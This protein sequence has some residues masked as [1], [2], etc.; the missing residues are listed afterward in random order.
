[1]KINQLLAGAAIGC[2]LGTAGI[3]L[4][5]GIANAAPQCP[6]GVQCGPGGGGGPGG[7]PPGGPP[8]ERGPGNGPPGERAP[9][10]LLT[11]VDPV[12]HPAV[13][14]VNSVDR[15]GVLAAHRPATSTAPAVMIGD[16][17]SVLRTTTG[18]GGSTVPL[19]QRAAA[20][21]LGRAAAADM[22]RTVAA[23]MG[24]AAAA[25]Q[26]L[27]LQRATGVGP[28]LQPVGFLFLR[29]LDSATGLTDNP[30]RRPPRIIRGGRQR[31][32]AASNGSAG[33]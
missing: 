18:A 25:D 24:P 8:G 3:S 15:E 10:E 28:R 5:S 23:G 31:V 2:M 21:G 22:G 32:S 7:P 13:R 26:L 20:V 4:G 29:D 19:G 14:P 16:R 12:A 30:A 27:R 33:A 6:P 1:M 11:T 17:R 9:V